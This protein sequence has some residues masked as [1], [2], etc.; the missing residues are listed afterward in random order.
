LKILFVTE[1]RINAGSVQAVAAYTAAGDKMGHTIAVYGYPDPAFPKIRF[2]ADACQFDFVVFILESKLD[3]L[4]GL[5]VARILSTVPL[6]RRVVLDADGLYNDVISFANYDRNHACTAERDRWREACERLGSRIFQATLAPRDPSVK[7]LLFYGYSPEAVIYN[8]NGKNFDVV[9]V[10]HNW[11]R[12][13]QLEESFFPVL[14]RIRERLGDICFLGL[15]WDACPSWA[16]TLGLADAFQVDA[17]QLRCLRITVRPPVPFTQVISTMSSA[18]INIMTQR[19]LF[20][21][22]GIITSKYFEV[23]SA[24]TVPLLLIDAELAA[25]IYGPAGK[26]LAIQGRVDQSLLGAL[27]S[28]EPY[29]ESVA[30]VREHLTTYHSYDVRVRQLV[31][32]LES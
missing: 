29:R 10:G 16:H 31:S 23:L 19:P 2:S 25:S 30:R 14:G 32:A 3:W 7:S 12:W 8:S 28:P 27:E 18:K 4:S 6:D 17:E 11:W 26:E 1:K 22:L 21:Q 15:W 24:D 5:R 9:H 20:Q 13:R